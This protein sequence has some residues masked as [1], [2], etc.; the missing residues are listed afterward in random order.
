MKSIM[1]VD[2]ESDLRSAVRTLLEMEGFA[3]HEAE[4][5]RVAL[6]FLN[7]GL[8]PDLLLVDLM[9]PEMDGASLC[10]AIRRDPLICGLRLLVVSGRHDAAQQAA[11]CGA[12]GFLGKPVTY[13][14]L[15]AAVRGYI[16]GNS[17]SLGRSGAGTGE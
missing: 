9:M 16:G 15:L 1:L 5:G 10:R 11:S 17:G 13:E 2:D 7:Q 4:N 8:R 6:E 14:N 3:V 12:D